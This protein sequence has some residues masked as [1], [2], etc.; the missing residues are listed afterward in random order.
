MKL[1]RFLATAALLG[2]A[3]PAAA[4]V[5][6]NGAGATFPNIIYGNWMLAYNNAHPEVQL[7][8][9]PIGSGGG[10]RQFS[11]GTPRRST[12]SCAATRRPAERSVAATT[13]WMRCTHRCSG[14]CSRT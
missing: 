3:V 9:Q 14:S 6:L 1:T 12:H 5:T 7:N 8:Y 4:Q 10:I 2:T 13:A 11:D